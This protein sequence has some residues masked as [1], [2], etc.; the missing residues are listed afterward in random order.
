MLLDKFYTKPRIARYCCSLFRKY[1]NPPIT[2]TIIEP[3]AG[4]GAFIPSIKTLTK[5][6][7]FIDIKPDHPQITK[8]NFLKYKK[9][10]ASQDSQASQESHPIH[11]IGNPPFGHR[12]S[13][14]IKFIKHASYLN[15]L[16][17]SFILPK[18]FKKSS[19]QK[20]VPLH[21]HLVYQADLPPYSFMKGATEYDVPCVF[22]IWVKKNKPRKQPRRH[23]VNSNYKFTDKNECDISVKRVGF[24][25]GRVSRCSM[26]DN[27]NTNY[28]IKLL[29]GQDIDAT[30]TRLNKIKFDKNQNTGAY[31]IP[32]QDF[33]QKYNRI[34]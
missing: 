32:K 6:Y 30:I 18:S 7:E 11:I 16:S 14:A 10:Q 3:S 28:F 24:G 26:S 15:A 8:G 17:I 19:M 31:S 5:S 4:S 27:E 23:Y 21:Y 25:I 12:A 29:K 2:D 1:V 9:K 34:L 20:T 33:I 13:T 22:Q